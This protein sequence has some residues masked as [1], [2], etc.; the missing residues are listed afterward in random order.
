MKLLFLDIDG[1]LRRDD[2]PANEFDPQAAKLLKSF[3]KDSGYKIVISSSWRRLGL[4]EDS[5]LFQQLHKHELLDFIYFP[6]W[7]TSLMKSYSLYDYEPVSL[8]RYSYIKQYLEEHPEVT[9]Y[10]ILDDIDH[11]FTAEQK[12]RFVQTKDILTIFELNKMIKLAE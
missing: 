4:G 1:V 10:I 11:Q 9:E 2:G 8:P 5:I 3:L 6:A 7:H 12:K